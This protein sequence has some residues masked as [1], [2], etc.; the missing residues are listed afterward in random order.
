MGEVFSSFLEGGYI[1]EWGSGNNSNNEIRKGKAQ[2]GVVS[3]TSEGSWFGWPALDIQ[4]GIGEK[5]VDWEAENG[6]GYARM[7]G[8]NQRSPVVEKTT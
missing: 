1:E 7:G 5:E 8:G 3:D 4:K 2:G 6:R